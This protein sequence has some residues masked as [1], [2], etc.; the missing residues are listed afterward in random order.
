MHRTPKTPSLFQDFNKSLV[1]ADT[2]SSRSL[3]EEQINNL[4]AMG[5]GGGGVP[6]KGWAGIRDVW[7]CEQFV[8]AGGRFLSVGCGGET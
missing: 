1:K 6:I 5:W 2:F 7:P 8:A 4:L 3:E